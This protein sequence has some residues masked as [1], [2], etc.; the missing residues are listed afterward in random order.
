MTIYLNK[1]YNSVTGYRLTFR[2][3]R[4]NIQ[5]RGVTLPDIF[6]ML[7]GESERTNLIYYSRVISS[8]IHST[9]R[10]KSARAFAY[11]IL[12][13]KRKKTSHYNLRKKICRH[14]YILL[15]AKLYIS[16]EFILKGIQSW[17]F[18]FLNASFSACFNV[19]F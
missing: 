12:L 13:K 1:W 15:L 3:S 4:M 9:T 14:S 16:K 8:P 18:L 6:V 17:W 7:N 11:K 10:T 19:L 5:P 2:T